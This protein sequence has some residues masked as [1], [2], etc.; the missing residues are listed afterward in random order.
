MHILAFLNSYSQGLSG[1]DACFLNNIKYFGKQEKITVITSLLGKELC[2]K[3]GLKADFRITSKETV[4]SKVI[5]TYLFRT[6]K[7]LFVKIPLGKVVL[8]A[9]SD[10][11]PDVLP[12]FIFKLINP[13]RIWIQKIYHLIPKKRSIP[14]LFQ[15]ISLGLIKFADLII[16]DNSNLKTDLEKKYHLPSKSITVIS[17]GVD[18]SY[19]KKIKPNPK[20]YDAIF[21]GQLRESK[22][23]FDIPVIWENVV[24]KY[25]QAHLAIIGKNIGDNQARLKKELIKKHLTKNVDILGFLDTKK[26]FSLL[27]SAK[28]LILPSFEEGFGMVILESLVCGTP[29]IAYDLPVFNEH[30]SAVITVVKINDTQS[31]SSRAI[32][33]IKTDRREDHHEIYNNYDLNNQVKKE[34]Q[35]IKNCYEKKSIS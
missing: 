32:N 34:Y 21:I 35:L 2:Q 8:Y 9:G 16:V 18:V 33:I 22:G 31:F 13:K 3:E 12:V 26:I 23:I 4:F 11:L 20:H 14:Y 30:F 10:F 17:P 5:I 28:C 24:K 19:I 6:L 27:K 25:P 7:A 1:G 29:V 15:R